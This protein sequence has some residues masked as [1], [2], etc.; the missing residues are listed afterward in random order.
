MGSMA[1]IQRFL[2]HVWKTIADEFPLFMRRLCIH[3]SEPL[4]WKRISGRLG[5]NQEFVSYMCE[6]IRMFC[7]GRE[8]PD[9]I[10]ANIFLFI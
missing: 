2:L 7:D 6:N 8:N 4:L 10:S 1:P 3:F 5:E 9:I